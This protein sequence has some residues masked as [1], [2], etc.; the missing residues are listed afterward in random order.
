MIAQTIRAILFAMGTVATRM[1]FRASRS[2]RRRSA[3]SCLCLARRTYA[4]DEELAQVLVATFGDADQTWFATGR[5][6][7]WYL[8]TVVLTGCP[9][10]GR[11]CGRVLGSISSS[12]LRATP[13]W[14]RIR[15]WRSSVISI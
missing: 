4:D 7:A 15:P 8:C 1:G 12:M 2:A 10:L 9:G 6:L 14:R 3:L 11:S 13:R 5:D